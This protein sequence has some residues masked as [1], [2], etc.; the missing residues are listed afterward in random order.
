M[1]AA[2][3]APPQRLLQLQLQHLLQPLRQLRLQPLGNAPTMTQ[4][5]EIVAVNAATAR[6]QEVGLA[7]CAKDRRQVTTVRLT[8]QVKVKTWPSR[9]WIGLSAV[10]Q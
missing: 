7:L 2:V 3:Q 6:T 4:G 1:P 8:V 9:V 10:M 5:L